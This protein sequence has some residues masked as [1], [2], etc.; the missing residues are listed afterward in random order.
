[1]KKFFKSK[2]G[3]KI[4]AL[5]VAVLLIWFSENFDA[6][7]HKNSAGNLGYVP[8]NIEDIA[9]DVSSDG[10]I[11]FT[12]NGTEF[13]TEFWD[14]INPYSIVNNNKPFFTLKEISY[15]EYEIYS[16]L[17]TLGRC[18]TAMACLSTELMPT[19]ERESISSVKP[20]GWH[21]NNNRYDWIDGTYIYNRCHLIGFQL[22]GENA[23]EKN[24]IT[25]TRYLNVEGMLPLENIVAD[26][27]K[28]TNNHVMYRITPLYKGDNRVAHGVLMEAF[29]VEDNGEVICFNVFCP[30]IQPGVA[31]DYSTGKN[32]A[33]V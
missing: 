12:A 8:E 1:M 20:S 28:E 29:S 25:G 15:E 21:G 11:S 13:T 16:E 31:I 26:Y 5:A 14:G 32:W 6:A 9:T 19:E 18:G 10:T 33:V 27:I 4:I 17:D 24:L 30:N 7:E 3:K 22:T 23:N 2:K